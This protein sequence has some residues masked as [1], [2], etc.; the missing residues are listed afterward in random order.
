[1]VSSSLQRSTVK[2][3]SDS[4]VLISCGL[5]RSDFHLLK[6]LPT[7]TYVIDL[8]VD[9]PTCQNGSYFRSKVNGSATLTQQWRWNRLYMQRKPHSVLRLR[10]HQVLWHAAC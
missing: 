3:D 9:V 6:E 5:A 4:F 8:A 2:R 10:Q 7:S 1:M